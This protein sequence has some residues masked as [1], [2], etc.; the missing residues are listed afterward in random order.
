[1][2]R[3]SE[4]IGVSKGSK[5][6]QIDGMSD[7]LKNSIWNL[8]FNLYNSPDNRTDNY[9][10]RVADYIAEFFRKV[11]KDNLPFQSYECRNWVKKY[12]Y[13]LDWDEVYDLTEFLVDNHSDMTKTYLSGLGIYHYHL[14]PKSE[15]ISE[16]NGLLERELS[17]Y[18]FVS[19]FLTPISDKVEVDEIEAAVNQATVEVFW[20]P[21]NTFVQH[22]SY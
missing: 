13:S 12:F 6:I 8:F 21:T 1:M 3:F 19:G 11:P 14:V 16:L 20:E 10:V 5:T 9:W 15:V 18:R 2:D 22:F 7:E 17:G 4:R